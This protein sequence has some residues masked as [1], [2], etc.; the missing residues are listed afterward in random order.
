MQSFCQQQELYPHTC[1]SDLPRD[2]L[3]LGI[4]GTASFPQICHAI[5][6]LYSTLK[7]TVKKYSNYFGGDFRYKQ[8][9]ITEYGVANGVS[10]AILSIHK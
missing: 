10:V 9:G 8:K 7:S 6:L 4:S 1:Q 3:D 2:K 5:L